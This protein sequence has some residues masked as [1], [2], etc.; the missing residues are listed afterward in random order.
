MNTISIL[1]SGFGYMMIAE[2][3]RESIEGIIMRVINDPNVALFP[4]IPTGV[5]VEPINDM[6]DKIILLFDDEE[7]TSIWTWHKSVDGKSYVLGKIE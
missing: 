4:T 1:R 3:S 7:V 2:K 6:S 5:K